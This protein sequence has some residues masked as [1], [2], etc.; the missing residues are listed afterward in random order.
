[1]RAYYQAW[2]KAEIGCLD[3]RYSKLV[4][5]ECRILQGMAA[6]QKP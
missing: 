2:V 6:E 5:V 1:M 4:Y 3:P